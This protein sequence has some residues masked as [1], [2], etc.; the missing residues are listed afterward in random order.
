MPRLA[1]QPDRSSVKVLT[2]NYKSLEL[3][4]RPQ[5]D[6]S[7]I[8]DLKYQFLQVRSKIRSIYD[9]KKPASKQPTKSFNPL[10]PHPE[11]E[12][13]KLKRKSFELLFRIS[14]G[15]GFRELDLHHLTLEE[16]K[17]VV[18]KVLDHLEDLMEKHS[19]KR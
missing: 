13:S 19:S 2:S 18:D 5:L 1:P 10:A 16:A 4:L 8:S 17:I 9:S 15:S 14:E 12:L 7:E 11:A 3:Q 6:S